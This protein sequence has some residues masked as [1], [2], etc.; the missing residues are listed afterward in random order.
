LDQYYYYYLVP[1]HHGM[2][3]AGACKYSQHRR[4]RAVGDDDPADQ[5]LELPRRVLLRACARFCYVVLVS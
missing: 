5:A 1:V 4:A 3:L 2:Q